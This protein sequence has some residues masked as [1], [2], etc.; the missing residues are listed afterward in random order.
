MCT[1]TPLVWYQ[2]SAEKQNHQDVCV[3]MIIY[4]YKETYYKVL[5]HVIMGADKSQDP[6]GG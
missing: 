3:C 5:A 2:C 1:C 4:N 6:E